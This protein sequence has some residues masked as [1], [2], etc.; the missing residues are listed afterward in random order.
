MQINSTEVNRSFL[1]DFRGSNISPWDWINDPVAFSSRTPAFL[2]AD[3]LKHTPHSEQKMKTWPG[4]H[5][6]APTTL[7]FM[8]AHMSLLHKQE[9]PVWETLG[10]YSSKTGETN[11]KTREQQHFNSLPGRVNIDWLTGKSEIILLFG[12]GSS[13]TEEE[14]SQVSKHTG[15]TKHYKEVS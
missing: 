14:P 9:L 13:D 4:N 10:H 15:L 8:N 6:K 7:S 11:T 2:E 5:W 3:G 1:M 12:E